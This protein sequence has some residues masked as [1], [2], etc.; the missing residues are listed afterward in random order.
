AGNDTLVAGDGGNDTLHGDAGADVLKLGAFLTATDQIDGGA[1]FDKAIL[2][3]NGYAAGIVFGATTMVN[4]EEIDLVAGNDYK[5]TLNTAT[6]ATGL[7]V[8]GGTLGAGD[9][10]TLNGAAETTAALTA[11]GGAANDSIVGGAGAD[12]IE[13]GGGADTLAGGTG[14]DTVSYAGSV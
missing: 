11:F 1:D 10:L 6:N 7:T 13:G 2:D 4:V 12:K 14:I 5:L 8:D 9:V 3:G